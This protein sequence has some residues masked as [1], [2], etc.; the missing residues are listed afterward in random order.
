MFHYKTIFNIRTLS[1][2]FIIVL[3]SVFFYINTKI[4]NQILRI[5]WFKK[6]FF[7]LFIINYNYIS[8]QLYNKTRNINLIFKYHFYLFKFLKVFL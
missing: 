2:L 7:F 4:I 5:N 8:I 3:A 6:K 1:F